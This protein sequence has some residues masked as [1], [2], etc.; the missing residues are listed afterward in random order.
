MSIKIRSRILFLVNIGLVILLLSGCAVP[1]ATPTE[2][3]KAD[4][5]NQFETELESLRQEMKIP[6]IS[7]QVVKNGQLARS[8]GFGFANVVTG[9]L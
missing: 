1:E 7:T 6:G 2:A 8:R 5:W 3:A 4:P 9:S